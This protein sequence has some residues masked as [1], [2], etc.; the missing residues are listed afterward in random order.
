MSWLPREL[1]SG[2]AALL[3]A[4]IP[5]TPVQAAPDGKAQQEITVTPSDDR[6]RPSAR[7]P[8]RERAE[9]TPAEQAEYDAQPTART[10]ISRLFSIAETMSPP[11]K[12]MNMAMA[13]SIT[14]PPMEREIVALAVLHLE[15]GEYEIAQHK[16]VARMMGITDAKVQAIADER[17]GDPI[18][19]AREKALLA[20]TR[21]VVK[22]VR[23]DGPTFDAVAAFYDRRQIMETIFVITNYMMILRL[24]EAVELPVDGTVGASFWMKKD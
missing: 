23:V 7:I 9:M 4:L 10:N 18:F 3:A 13:T 8:L 17:Y 16:E 22:S 14:V 11:L 24:T 2:A 20:F 12:A 6:A 5:T 19:D 21:Q 1:A 15:R